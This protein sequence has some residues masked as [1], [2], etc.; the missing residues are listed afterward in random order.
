MKSI[1]IAILNWNGEKLLRRFLKE[2]VDH[3]PEAVVYV[4]D[5]ASSDGSVEYLKNHFTGVRLIELDKNYG[6]AGGYNRGLKF[7]QE[8][9]LCLLNNDVSVKPGWLAPVLNHFDQH[10]KTAIAQPHVLDLNRPRYFEYAG[11]AGGFIDRLGYP[12]CRGR[13]FYH[14]EEDRGQYDQDQKVFWASGACFF[15]RKKVFETLEGFDE[16][17]F[18]HMEEI[19]LCW[20]V[21]QK[22]MEVYSLWKTKVY[23]QGGGTLEPSPMKTYLNFRN[24][25]YLLLKNL[26]KKKKSRIFERMIW[27]GIAFVFFLFQLK[28]RHAFAIPKAHFYFYKNYKKINAKRKPNQ[29]EVKYFTHKLMPI[30]YFFLKTRKYTA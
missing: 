26:P 18:A 2:V 30:R 21:F 27:D 28:F 10:P 20:R 24:S 6:Y 5:N 11:A 23:H 29:L 13:V 16:D 1:G 8:K 19:D 17:F 4:I 15:V 25:L 3:S 7:I 12:Y 9:L 22:N 14:L